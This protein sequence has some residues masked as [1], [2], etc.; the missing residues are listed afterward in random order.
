[1]GISLQVDINAPGNSV[2]R[3]LSLNDAEFERVYLQK[4]EEWWGE[5]VKEGSI[6]CARASCG[7]RISL[8]KDFRP[9]GGKNYCT[10]CYKEEVLEFARSCRPFDT[11]EN[12]LSLEWHLRVTRVLDGGLIRLA[13]TD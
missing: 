11:P 6:Q 13:E 3:E 1:M 5:N 10:S 9:N 7:K 8:S 12:I 2:Y 4:N